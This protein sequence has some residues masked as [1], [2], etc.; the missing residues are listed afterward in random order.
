MLHCKNFKSDDI[1]FLFDTDEYVERR[2]YLGFCPQCLKEV[3]ELCEIRKIDNNVSLKRLTGKKLEKTKE[4]EKYNII[5]TAQQANKSRF[6]R[7][8]G[9]VYGVNKLTKNKTAIKQYRKDFNGTRE[10]VKKI[11]LTDEEKK[12]DSNK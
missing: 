6:K 2:L 1:W 10:L 8:F 3:G 11:D 7:P 4:R 9:W 12:D 5:Y